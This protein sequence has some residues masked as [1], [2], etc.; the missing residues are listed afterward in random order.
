M[1]RIKHFVISELDGKEIKKGRLKR[2]QI[3]KYWQ[4][5]IKEMSGKPSMNFLIAKNIFEL[6]D[7]IIRANKDS[8]V[9]FDETKGLNSSGGCK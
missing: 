4:M 1:K 2:Y 8:I 9:I 6:R 7:N 3:S 5:Q